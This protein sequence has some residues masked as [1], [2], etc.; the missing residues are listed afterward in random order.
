LD[1]HAI[2]TE[3]GENELHD[4]AHPAYLRHHFV[5]VDQQRET[6]SFGMWLFLLTEIMFFGGLFMAYLLYRNW[7][8]DAFVASS[9]T[10]GIG[11][12]TTNTAVLILSSF[13]MAW[14]FS[15]SRPSSITT[16]TPSI[17]FRGQASA[18]R[19]LSIPPIS[20]MCRWLRIWRSMRSCSFSCTLP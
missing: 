5:T 6:A 18:W 11:L 4:E 14:P 10:L 13:T 15:A 19:T 17:I 12:G 3:H 7:Y 1:S 16:N 8:Y 9:N 20:E 2:A